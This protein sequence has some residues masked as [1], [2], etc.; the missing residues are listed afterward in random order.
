MDGHYDAIIIGGG[1]NGLVTACYLAKAKWKVLVLERRYIVG[2]ACVTEE[3]FP[4]FKVS[5]AAYVNS[6]FDKKIVRDLR[7]AARPRRDA[8]GAEG[9]LHG[10]PGRQVGLAVRPQRRAPA[11][12]GAARLWSLLCR[13][14][15]G[16]PGHARP[17]KIDRLRLPRE[18]ERDLAEAHAWYHA[19]SSRLARVFLE[20]VN[21]S[22][23][24]IL[25]H[26]EAHQVIDRRTRRALLRRFPYAVFFV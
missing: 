9:R 19:Q 6:L 18:A 20:A 7:L 3:T 13:R 11:P 2:G 25:R 15:E 16:R 10:P 17:P 12:G 8:A 5:T 26:P 23:R 14:V 21:T 22:L 4:G 24:S 1:H